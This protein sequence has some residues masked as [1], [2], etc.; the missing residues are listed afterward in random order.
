M[1]TEDETLDQ[2]CLQW[3]SKP[4]LAIDTEFMRVDS[5][6]PKIALLQINDGENNFLIDPLLISNWDKFK[7]LMLNKNITKVF[8]SCS[9]DLLVFIHHFGLLPEPIF[10]TQVGNAFLNQGF[11]L[12][13]QNLVAQRT[14]VDIPKG[15]TRSD[16]LRRPLS[17]EQLEYAALD[18]AYLPV[19]YLE[20]EQQLK[21]S[22]RLS[23]AQEDCQRLLGNYENEINQDFSQSY[24]NFS[25]AWQLDNQELAI[26]KVLAEWR[27]QRARLRNKPR[28]WIIRDKEL[29]TIV[30]NKPVTLSKLQSLEGM[31]SNFINYEGKAVID[32]IKHI[33]ANSGED[34]PESL[35]RPLTGAQKKIFKKLQALLEDKAEILSIPV[36][37]LGRRKLLMQLF[38]AVLLLRESSHNE[39]FDY[40][41]LQL[42]EE[43][44]GWR[45]EQVLDDLLELLK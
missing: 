43:F 31:H 28:N 6:Y 35:P 1:L 40:A 12:S 14:G 2:Y 3:Q 20:L 33:L 19:I 7:A 34:Y 29:L 9:E 25:S 18:V 44:Q 32:S 10:D 24:L 30:K 4:F 16:W 8:H 36:E 21:A 26:L 13:Y 37:I 38:Y 17:N 42:P 23:W 39:A 27:E 45:K 5:F 41:K 11:G 22:G 15:E